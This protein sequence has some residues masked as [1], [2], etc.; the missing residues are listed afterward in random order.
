MRAENNSSS[1]PA[2]IVQIF[3]SGIPEIVQVD[4][5]AGNG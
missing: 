2:A 5:N 4:G 3:H 1:F